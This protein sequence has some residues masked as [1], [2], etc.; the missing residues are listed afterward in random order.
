VTFDEWDASVADGGCDGYR[1]KDQDWGR[2]SRPVVNVS[3]KDANAY[4]AWLSR[5]TGRTYRL[6]REAEWEYA[7]RAA[8]TTP[9]Q[10]P[11]RARR[12]LE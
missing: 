6:L 2:G 5:K 4:V 3:W 7:A 9:L 8:T 12:F 1:P 10:S 11:S